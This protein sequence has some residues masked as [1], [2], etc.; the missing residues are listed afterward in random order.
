[1]IH[2]S[3]GQTT[4]DMGSRVVIVIKMLSYGRFIISCTVL[5][6]RVSKYQGTVIE[7]LCEVYTV[8]GQPHPLMIVLSHIGTYQLFPAVV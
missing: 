3:E 6:T 7:Q 1:M 4:D 2:I 8:S 5:D